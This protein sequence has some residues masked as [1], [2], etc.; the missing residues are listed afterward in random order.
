MG[1]FNTYFVPNTTVTKAEFLHS[2][3]SMALFIFIIFLARF[4]LAYINKF[5]FRMIGIRMSA[6]IRAH[7][8]R[9]LF[10]QTVHVLDTS[11]PTLTFYLIHPL[12][13]VSPLFGGSIKQKKYEWGFEN[14]KWLF[15]Y[16]T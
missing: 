6:A 16:I 3:D 12:A 14:W 7:Y 8:I 10:E 9:C 2:V 11:K 5:A 1:N 4:F 13:S 15:V